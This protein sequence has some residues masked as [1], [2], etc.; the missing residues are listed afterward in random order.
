MTKLYTKRGDAGITSICGGERVAKTDLRV[1]ACG[2]IDELNCHIGVLQTLVADESEW[3]MLGSIQ[4]NLF[5]LSTRLP[6]TPVSANERVGKTDLQQLETAID[7]L[8]LSTPP[9]DTFILPGGCP[10][11]AQS[12]VCRA[13]CRR[14]ERSVVALAQKCNIEP[15]IMSYINRLSDYFFILAMNLNFIAQVP[16][17]KLYISCK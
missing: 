15:V 5:L 12:H 6:E 8:Q 11:A 1:Q 3:E 2:D 10:G 16:E 13:V 17:K 4:R 9:T 14:A 7:R